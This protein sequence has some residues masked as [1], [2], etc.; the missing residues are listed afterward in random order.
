MQLSKEQLLIYKSFGIL[1]AVSVIWITWNLATSGGAPAV[2]LFRHVTGLP[3]PSCGMTHSIMAIF[4][5]E[6][7]EAI[8]INVLGFVAVLMMLVVP[9]L[10]LV[11]LIFRKTYF[12]SIYSWSENLIKRN[13]VVSIPLILL[14]IGNWIYLICES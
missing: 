12:I 8:H 11:D 9:P 2:C 3:C 7:K 6:M 1:S 13:L 4:N 10:L 5:F 14:V